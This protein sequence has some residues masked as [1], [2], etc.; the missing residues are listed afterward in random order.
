MNFSTQTLKDMVDKIKIGDIAA[1]NI[2]GKN[3]NWCYVLEWDSV[4]YTSQETCELVCG[5]L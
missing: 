1:Q 4:T 3:A 5:E 2:N